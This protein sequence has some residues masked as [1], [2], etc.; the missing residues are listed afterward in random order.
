[1]LI[2]DKCLQKFE[3]CW[4]HDVSW[5]P[6]K[7]EGLGW[8]ELD[9]LEFLAEVF[10]QF[11]FGEVAGGDDKPSAVW[12]VPGV[13]TNWKQFMLFFGNFEKKLE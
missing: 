10:S 8:D 4:G 12:F 3:N 9:Q 5:H 6:S 7:H 11:L 13:L 1:M 2:W